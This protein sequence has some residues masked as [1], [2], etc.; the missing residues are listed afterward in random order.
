VTSA[1]AA[2]DGL[3]PRSVLGKVMNV[4]GSFAPDDN[5]VTLAE[6]GRRTGIPKGTLHRVVTDLVTA[7]L[8][9]R[10]GARYRLSTRLFELGMRASVERTLVDLATPFMEDLYELTHETVN[11]GVREEG[12]VM[13][14]S[15]I[16]GHRQSGTRARVGGRMPLHTTA[17]GK[18]LLAGLPSDARADY[19]RSPLKRLS[20][21]TIVAPGILQQQ[22][23]TVVECGVSYEFEE[24]QIGIVC[25]G[26]PV[27]ILDVGTIAAI[28]VTGPIGR[29]NAR[30][31]GNLV[32]AAAAGISSTMARRDAIQRHA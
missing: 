27:V 1:P 4:L 13:Y 28:S 11:L 23:L 25:V 17:I 29:F 16:G 9:N 3:D 12:E 6:L 8:L 14:L 10:T 21:R 32:H 31:H 22:L 26:A 19:L 5:G 2:T 18:A 24:T 15:K 30:A 20:P 7:R